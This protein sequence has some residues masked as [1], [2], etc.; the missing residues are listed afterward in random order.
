MPAGPVRIFVGTEEKTKVPFDVLSY[1]IRKRTSMD[2]EITP[3]IGPG[4]VVPS[5]LHQGTGFSLRRFMIPKACGYKGYA[6]YMDADQQVFG[7]IA[8]L[9]SYGDKLGGKAVGCT[10]QTDKFSLKKPWAQTSVMIIDC[11]KCGWVPERLWELLRSGF[12]YHNFMHLTF[13]KELPYEIPIYWNHLN[14][15]KKG[16]TK[17]LHYTKEPE[18]PWYKPDHPLA[19][20]WEEDF[21]KAVAEGAVSKSDFEAA[22]ALW[23][24]PKID[25]RPKQ[26]FNPYYRKYLANFK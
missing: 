25:K 7:D 11:E 19:H 2:V 17:L 15:Y 16:V 22:L 12:V 13:M 24:A 23:N 3:M 5:G 4:W 8:E 14:V 18:Q 21:V 6:I 9:W 26:G 20:L 10:Y 1:S